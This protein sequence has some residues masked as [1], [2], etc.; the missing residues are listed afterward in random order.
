MLSGSS[1]GQMEAGLQ[2]YH[3]IKAHKALAQSFRALNVQGH[4][5]SHLK[6]QTWLSIY[7][8]CGACMVH[9]C[10]VIKLSPSLTCLFSYMHHL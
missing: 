9:E 8:Y 5:K 4:N 10:I 6:K 2:Q 3:I 7:S 1:H